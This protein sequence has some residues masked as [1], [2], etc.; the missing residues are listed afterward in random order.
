MVLAGLH[1]FL[2]G[3]RL[4][5]IVNSGK[6][7]QHACRMSMLTPPCVVLEGPR[8]GDPIVLFVELLFLVW[9]GGLVSRPANA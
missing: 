3:I 2:L 4:V 9:L 1:K 5:R 7:V 6:T 8:Q